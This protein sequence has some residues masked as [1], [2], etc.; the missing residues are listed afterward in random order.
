MK[1][2]FLPFA[3][4]LADAAGEI[5]RPYF[6]AHGQVEAK[7]DESPVTAA[8]RQAET[9]IRG[10]IEQAYPDHAIYGEEFGVQ[11]AGS[12]ETPPVFTWVIDPIDGTRAFIAGR[13]EW[14]TLIALCENGVPILGILDQPVTGERWIGVAG[15]PTHYST[16]PVGA[17]DMR[18]RTGETPL[19]ARPCPTLAQA[20]FSTTSAAYFTPVQ[21]G[22]VVALAQACRATVK[23]GDCYAYG[24]LARG[25]RDVVVDAGLKP[26]D[27]LALVP[28]IEGAGGRITGWDGQPITL[29]HFRE[30]LATGD[31]AL[32]SQA[33]ALLQSA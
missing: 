19:A 29:D 17:P 30:V 27:I 32:H 18:L 20:E 12:R 8:D 11:L 1:A 10:L 4:Q 6:G 25:L 16:V 15:E 33:L 7:H 24:L 2:E 26:Y 13:K 21:A 22:R 23:D 28:I 9:A 5:I 3:R 14:G 31:K